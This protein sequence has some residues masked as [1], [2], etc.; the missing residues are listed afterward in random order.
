MSTEKQSHA[1][2]GIVEGT[3]LAGQT[4][5]GMNGVSW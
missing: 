4:S 3:D 1:R 5:P 2:I